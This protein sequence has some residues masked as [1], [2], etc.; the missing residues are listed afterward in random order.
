MHTIGL[1]RT[2]LGFTNILFFMFGLIGFVICVWCAFNTEFFR[3][4]N[5]TVTKSSMVDVVAKFVNMK[6]WLTPLTSILIPV[7]MLAMM[8][9]CCGVLG[10]GCKV[11]CAIKTYVFLVSVLSLIAFW[12][13]FITGVYNIYSNNDST[14]KSM[15]QSIHKYYGKEN[16]LITYMWDYIMVKHQ[17]C[18]AD[19]YRDFS[20]SHWQTLNPKKIYPIQCC[21]LANISSLVPVSKDCSES[22]D[23][24]IQSNK[25]MGCFNAL[26]SAILMNKGKIIFYIILIAFVYTILTTFAYCIIRGEPLLGSMA[27]Q[28]TELLPSKPREGV[29]MIIPT[30]ASLNDMVYVEEPPK[31]VVKVVSAANPFQ[32]YKFTPN[33]Y[34]R[35][36]DFRAHTMRT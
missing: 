2:C 25:D 22:L 19:S 35:P 28:F 8:T 14:R 33:A 3:D 24:N 30:P 5:Y 27:G 31:K 13:F 11:K 10:A 34:S 4:V 20:K 12:L 32:S 16:D 6:L 36:E 15:R 23:P 7:A 18:G 1:P 9:S 26:R 21:K 29:N 17:C